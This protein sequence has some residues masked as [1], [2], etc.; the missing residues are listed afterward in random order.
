[1]EI[2]IYYIFSS[3]QRVFAFVISLWCSLPTYPNPSRGSGPL[4]Y[5]THPRSDLEHYNSLA[6]YKDH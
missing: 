3:Y 5:K 2:E 4:T 6:E 1:M